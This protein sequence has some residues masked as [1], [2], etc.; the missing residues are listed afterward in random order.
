MGGMGIS[1]EQAVFV[2]LLV[3]SSR[4]KMLLLCLLLGLNSFILFFFFVPDSEKSAT[5]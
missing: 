2:F 4:I 1:T 5:L 3:L